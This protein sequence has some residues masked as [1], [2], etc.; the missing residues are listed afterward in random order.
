MRVPLKLK[1]YNFISKF[2]QQGKTPNFSMDAPKSIRKGEE[3][4]LDKLKTY[5]SNNNID[6]NELLIKQF[7][8]GYSNLTYFLKSSTQE[9]VLRRPPF[10][11]KSLQGG[12]DVFREYNVLKNITN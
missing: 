6:A 1:F 11:V 3:L 7:P 2:I 8:S 4:A 9:F 5:L 12:H 10:G